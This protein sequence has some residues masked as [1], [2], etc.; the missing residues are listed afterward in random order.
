MVSVKVM[1][2]WLVDENG[3]YQ[4]HIASLSVEKLPLEIWTCAECGHPCTIRGDW[5]P[6]VPSGRPTAS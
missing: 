6:R 1:E 5:A 2:T 3:N 4:K